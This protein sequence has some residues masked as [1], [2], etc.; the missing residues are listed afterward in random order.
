VTVFGRQTVARLAGVIAALAALSL[1]A[2][3]AA[4][5]ASRSDA[6]PGADTSASGATVV[7]APAAH[8]ALRALAAERVAAMSLRERAAS[9]VMGHVAGTDPAVLRAYMAASEI[10]GFILMGA[11]VPAD[12]DVLRDITA[13][14]TLDPE[15]PPLIA[16]DQEGG[17]VSRLPWD[18]LPSARALK[19]A[20]PAAATE[21]F[22]AR[23]AL[24]QRAG[25]S[26]NFGIV[27]DVAAGP[28]EF[29]YSRALGTD[30]TGA[31]DR[32]AAAV[33]GEA[34]WA[35]STIKH[36]P[37]HGAA[38][39]D[40]HETIPSTSMAKGTWLTFDARPFAAGI[41]AG[42]DMLMFGHLAYTAVDPLPASLSAEWHRVARE[43]LGFD[44]VAITDDLGML[45]ASGDPAFAD[46]VANAVTAL[47][48]GN[49]MVL[50]VMFSN[51]T[52]ATITVDGIVAAVESGQ[53]AAE[54]LD[55]A[56]TR[57]TEARLR[58]AAEGRGMAPCSSCP[59]AG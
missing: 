2:P 31:A 32:T 57:V 41:D 19:T 48:A 33:V 55:E 4:A 30:V 58:V 37:G 44:G 45:Q 22:A 36:F 15:L 10:G 47:V 25:I 54:R 21:A 14:L 40:S 27:A 35:L 52:S 43:E 20:P 56:A 38:P 3:V 59:P 17:D 1:G 8:D 7:V 50:S 23:G 13:G 39:G 11:N 18:D 29:I 34:G 9:V 51:P 46:P 42:A 26:V 28:G 49:D 24:L 6:T 16:I 53:L 5:S 12:E